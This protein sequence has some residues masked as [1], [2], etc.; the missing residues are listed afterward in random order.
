M[1]LHDLYEIVIYKVPEVITD[2]VSDRNANDL[3]FVTELLNTV[4]G[5]KLDQQAFS[6]MFSL[7]RKDVPVSHQDLF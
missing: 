7:S 2:Y 3:A 6:R 4:F 5:L 1:S